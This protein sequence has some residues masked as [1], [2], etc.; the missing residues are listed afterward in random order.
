MVG[1]QAVLRR[2]S[3]ATN[4]VLDPLTLMAGPLQHRCTPC[5]VL[6]GEQFTVSGLW[7]WAC[8]AR[9]DGRQDR[10]EVAQRRVDHSGDPARDTDT[11][12]VS[13]RVNERNSIGARSERFHRRR[14]SCSAPAG[15]GTINGIRSCVA[16]S[17]AVTRSVEGFG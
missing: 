4:T 11:F 3:L 17:Q 7:G 15:C 16:S 2:R 5:L 8:H 13:N 1:D 14:E 12:R 6:P 10:A 9:I